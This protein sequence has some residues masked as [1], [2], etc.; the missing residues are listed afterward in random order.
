MVRARN[1]KTMH[2]R[3]GEEQDQRLQ[4]TTV[5][6]ATASA[7]STLPPESSTSS[8]IL[9]RVN[10]YITE[11]FDKLR[12]EMADDYTSSEAVEQRVSNELACM[13][14]RFVEEYKMFEAIRKA[15][16]RAMANFKAQLVAVS[17]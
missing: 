3:A 17:D 4:K 15:I 8:V 9:V 2:R 13:M 14:G 6:P 12:N 11:Q 1:W 16:D 7:P 10:A 5:S